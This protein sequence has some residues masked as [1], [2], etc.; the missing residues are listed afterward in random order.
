MK[1]LFACTALLCFNS[2]VFAQERLVALGQFSNDLEEVSGI[3]LDSQGQTLWAINDAGNRAIIYGVNPTNAQITTKLFVDNAVNIDWE[4]IC[5]DTNNTLYVGD[6]GNNNF[7]RKTFTIYGISNPKSGGNHNVEATAISFSFPEEDTKKGKIKFDIEAFVFW[8]GQF[9]FFTKTKNDKFKDKTLVYCLNP[10]SDQQ[11]ARYFGEINLCG[12]ERNCKITGAAV[13]LSS[14]TLAL[15]SH[16]NLWILPSFNTN[17]ELADATKIR[18]EFNKATQKEGVAF[19]NSNTVL[20]S[21][22][23]TKGPNLLYRLSW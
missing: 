8:E 4:A 2:W 12:K 11:I 7:N 9:Y 18:Y 10:N 21:E 17:L 20:I 15:I 22:E 1:L 13:E 14:G 6:F 5:S 23:K 16:K 19:V 3:N